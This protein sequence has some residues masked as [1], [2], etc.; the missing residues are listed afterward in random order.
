MPRCLAFLMLASAALCARAQE[1]DPLNTTECR[2]A[3]AQL[4]EAL[5]APRRA[6]STPNPAVVK[7]RQQAARACLGTET[8]ERKRSG[9]PEPVQ[10]VPPPRITLRP[11]P[12]VR[13][14]Q[15][16]PALAAPSPRTAAI[17]GCD[18]AGCWDSN[19][20]RLNNMGPVLLGPRGACVPLAG[21]L[22]CP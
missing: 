6:V 17:T 3:R 11:M 9:A 21:Q 8:G 19:G 14:P 5:A 15:P 13:P 18:L 16:P 22:T 10:A 7:A 2:A 4:E 20:Q 1:A 12:E